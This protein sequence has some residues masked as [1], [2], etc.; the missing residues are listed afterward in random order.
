M[1]NHGRKERVPVD[2]YTIEHILPQNEKLSQA[3]QEALGP[4][5]QRIQQ[6]W[7]HSL[8]NLT[9][10]GYN[11]EYSDRPFLDKRDMEKGGFKT[12]PLRLNEGLGQVE[13]WDEAAIQARAERLASQAV[14]VWKAPAI[15]PDILDAYQATP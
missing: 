7:L 10:T 5:W 4:E 2:E 8:G 12:S 11:P 15:A 3:W 14:G 1:E 9:L 13:V 6:T